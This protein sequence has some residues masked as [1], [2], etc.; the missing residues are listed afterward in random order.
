MLH[1]RIL[2]NVLFFFVDKLIII[3]HTF[4]CICI[5]ILHIFQ[6]EWCSFFLL[7]LDSE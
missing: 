7:E 1:I 5:I 3:Y 4:F 6:C 2:G